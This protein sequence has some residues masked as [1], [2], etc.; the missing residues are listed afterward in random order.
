MLRIGEGEFFF[1][2]FDHVVADFALVQMARLVGGYAMPSPAFAVFGVDLDFTLLMLAWPR[3]ESHIRVSIYQMLNG[4]ID[5][6]NVVMHGS[7]LISHTRE[8]HPTPTRRRR[9]FTLSLSDHLIQ[10]KSALRLPMCYMSL[11]VI[12]SVDHSH[13]VL[14]ELCHGSGI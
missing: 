2:V 5:D 11:S 12:L 9:T 13:V 6:L 8:I 10:V 7:R 1:V 14:S 3:Q 4:F